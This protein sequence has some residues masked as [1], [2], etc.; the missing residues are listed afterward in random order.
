MISHELLDSPYNTAVMLYYCYDADAMIQ[1]DKGT[2]EER[3][4][5]H[6]PVS[7]I[8]IAVQQYYLVFLLSRIY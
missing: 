3:S 4:F 7:A 1:P 2:R 6:L 8:A 5:R